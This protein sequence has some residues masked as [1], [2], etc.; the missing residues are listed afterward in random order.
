MNTKSRVLPPATANSV[1]KCTVCMSTR[2]I[3]KEFKN[4]KALG[5]HMR[6]FRHQP[7]RTSTLS[8]GKIET[9]TGNSNI[10]ASSVA[11][12]PGGEGIQLPTGPS[13]F[14]PVQPSTPAESKNVAKPS[15][16]I[17]TIAPVSFFCKPCGLTFPTHQELKQH[18]SQDLIPG[19]T[20]MNG[21]PHPKCIRCG[22]GFESHDDA[23]SHRIKAHP[24]KYCQ[25]CKR[26]F[27]LEE[28]ERHLSDFHRRDEA[29]ANLNLPS[30]SNIR[31]SS[32]AV[33]EVNE[34]S[35]YAAKVTVQGRPDEDSE[36][37]SKKAK[38]RVL[39]PQSIIPLSSSSTQSYTFSRQ[40]AEEELNY[41]MINPW[42]TSDS[43][44]QY[45]N[46]Q[47]ET[48]F[49]PLT[50]ERTPLSI[51][52]IPPSS[53]GSLTSTNSDSSS[54][55]EFPDRP[56]SISIAEPSPIIH[57]SLRRPN[58][59]LDGPIDPSPSP[60][61][62]NPN[63]SVTP[64]QPP[65]LRIIPPHMLQNRRISDLKEG[66]DVETVLSP[67]TV[68]EASRHTLNLNSG[69]ANM[70]IPVHN[71]QQQQQQQHLTPTVTQARRSIGGAFGAQF[72]A[73]SLN[74]NEH[75]DESRDQPLMSV[76]NRLN[77][78]DVNYQVMGGGSHGSEDLYQSWYTLC[79]MLF[80]PGN[81]GLGGPGGLSVGN[82]ELN[83]PVSV[84]S[85]FAVTNMMRYIEGGG[86]GEEE[87][88]REDEEDKT[89]RGDDEG[90]C[91]EAQG[92][93]RH[94][95]EGTTLQVGKD[96]LASG[97]ET[98][99][100]TT[101]VSNSCSSSNQHH[102]L[103]N[104]NH[105]HRQ[106]HHG[107]H[108]NSKL[109]PIPST[110]T[111]RSYSVSSSVLE[112]TPITVEHPT[113][114]TPIQPTHRHWSARHAEI[115][116]REEERLE[117][118]GS[119][120]RLSDCFDAKSSGKSVGERSGYYFRGEW[121][122]IPPSTTY[123]DSDLEAD[124]ISEYLLGSKERE[125]GVVTELVE[126]VEIEVR[127]RQSH[128]KESHR[129][130]KTESVSDVKQPV[131]L[132]NGPG[133]DSKSVIM[134]GRG[135]VSGRNNQNGVRTHS[136]PSPTLV[137]GGPS[138]MNSRGRE[139]D[140]ATDS[141]GASTMTRKVH[142]NLH[143]THRD[144]TP[145]HLSSPPAGPRSAHKVRPLSEPHSSQHGKHG[146]KETEKPIS[147]TVLRSQTTTESQPSGLILNWKCRLCDIPGSQ[148][149]DPTVT[150][151]GHLFCKECIVGWMFGSNA[152][153]DPSSRS[154]GLR[155]RAGGSDGC[156][157]CGKM[158]MV[159]MEV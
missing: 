40:L 111:S 18:Q 152:E 135:R 81:D 53:L 24:M 56:P 7:M 105:R 155:M 117:R 115:E 29:V 148:I 151:C 63:T 5:D 70:N 119:D 44:P 82:T 67:A 92:G 71:G 35:Q 1:R 89:G 15:L 93:L 100:K 33:N 19:K 91:K 118:L 84:R 141:S 16:S 156:P 122:R 51:S 23:N 139:V 4:E 114:S 144:Q 30:S 159:R 21:R 154:K 80:R 38:T 107:N 14:L 120:E 86:M 142:Q 13:S 146:V 72:W 90:Q 101:S 3:S 31:S 54:P 76:T 78:N 77:T 125:S 147:S 83:T 150:F 74:A 113:T 106:H 25:P 46:R 85:G 36:K 129:S 34:S 121:V 64:Q 136:R 57:H 37:N 96:I 153:L 103:D 66:N 94:E 127:R 104:R 87:G 28:E 95:N 69:R 42:S 47:A 79:K 88:T 39:E 73:P 60:R 137:S 126:E 11:I 116:R 98:C 138:R 48:G 128:E 130:E 145:K 158:F 2:G 97:D 41:N 99:R 140:E 134:E 143:H 43:S 26:Y 68:L 124:R 75:S 112:N 149:K 49:T 55:T 50:A 27:Y 12:L 61:P 45:S 132:E 102:T 9:R 22:E 8:A 6:D 65:K 123:E 59:I 20:A 10:Q 108:S 133:E 62:P 17:T 110:S 157:V 109:V 32:K 58:I 131:M 52:I